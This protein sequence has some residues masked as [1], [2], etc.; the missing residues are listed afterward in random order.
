MVRARYAG[1]S[2]RQ[3]LCVACAHPRDNQYT[4]E[5]GFATIST[6]IA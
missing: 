6:P 4:S 1:S 3:S 5:T 2:D